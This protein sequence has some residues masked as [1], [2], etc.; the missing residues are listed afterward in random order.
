MPVVDRAIAGPGIVMY[1]DAVTRKR[2]TCPGTS[3]YDT[4]AEARKD[5]LITGKL[6]ICMAV[7]RTFST[8][9]TRYQT[10]DPVMPILIQ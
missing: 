10:D 2:L 3:S 5:P 6:H 9:L 7:S 8:F 1:V 4:H